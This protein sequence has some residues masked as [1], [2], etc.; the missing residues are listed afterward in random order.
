MVKEVWL[1]CATLLICLVILLIVLLSP[2]RS[3]R[4]IKERD[5]AKAKRKKRNLDVLGKP[6]KIKRRT[7]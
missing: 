5:V 2:L 7:K 3:E 1:G 6:S 4:K